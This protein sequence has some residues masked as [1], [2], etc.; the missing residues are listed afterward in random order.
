VVHAYRDGRAP[1]LERVRTLGIEPVVFSVTGTSE[2]AALLVADDRGASVIVMV[3]SHNNLEEFLDKNRAGMASTFL[4]RLRVGG[5]LVD[6]KGVSRLYRQRI[7]NTQLGTLLLA[8]MLAI[9]AALATTPK[10]QVAYDLLGA[11][12]DGL[13]AFLRSFFV[14]ARPQALLVSAWWPV[15]FP[16]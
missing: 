2:D 13:W 15:G 1:G 8:G 16:S 11:R 7:S 5:K 4:I 9:G 3:G 12:L 14:D 6:A 10:G